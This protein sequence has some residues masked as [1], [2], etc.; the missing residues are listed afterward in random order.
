MQAYLYASLLFFSSISSIIAIRLALPHRRAP[1]APALMTMLGALF[2]WSFTYGIYWLVREPIWK[3]FWL[4][5]TY[6]G[7]TVAPVSFFVFAF[8]YTQWDDWL[9]PSTLAILFVEPILVLVFVWTDPWHGLYFAGKRH[10][11]DSVLLDG[12]P[13]FWFHVVYSY[14]LMIVATIV[15]IRK[16]FLL[17]AFYRWQ[18]GLFVGSLMLPWVANGLMLVRWTAWPNLDITPITFTITAL[19]IFY[20]LLGWRLLDIVPIARDLLIEKMHDGWLV[21]DLQNRVVD[22]NRVAQQLFSEA[23]LTVGLPV[24]QLFHK[25]PDI[26]EQ[27]IYLDD[28]ETE[29]YVESPTPIYIDLHIKPIQDKKGIKV[30]RLITWRDITAYKQAQQALQ[31]TNAQ[32]KARVEEI[33]TLRQELQEQAIRDPLT[34]VYNRRFLNEA[35]EREFRRAKRKKTFLTILIMDLDSFK[36]INDQYGH[37]AGDLALQSVATTLS[38]NIRLIDILCRYGGEEFV[39]LMPKMDRA[40]AFQRAEE[41]RAAIE[42]TT[43]SSLK[44]TFSVTA[45]LGLAVYPDCEG[46]AEDLLHAADDAL[47]AA[48]RQGKNKVVA[49]EP[50]TMIKSISYE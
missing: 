26:L 49:F 47:Y 36:N 24:S 2:A 29:L 39:I 35:L 5:M 20:D 10:L 9:T 44:G 1:G 15:L 8:R 6:L 14:G 3:Y 4:N 33:E 42:T 18:L 34:G 31:T 13:L 7:V 16:A 32:L 11:T 19:V 46:N 17:L 40:T 38:R 45:S 37:R 43:V 22:F 25:R 21:L 41:L 50:G 48:K 23:A 12:S 30:G 27:F 28:I